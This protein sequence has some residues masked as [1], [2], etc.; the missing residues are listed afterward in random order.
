MKKVL[1]KKVWGGDSKGKCRQANSL[2]L[3]TTFKLSLTESKPGGF[4]SPEKGTTAAALSV[5]RSGDFWMFLATNIHA[6]VAQNFGWLFGPVWKHYFW[7]KNSYDWFWKF[8]TNFYSNIWSHWQKFNEQ[9]FYFLAIDLHRQE[10]LNRI[11]ALFF[12][13]AV[14]GS[15]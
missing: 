3:S 13:A 9:S 1:S 2:N 10:Y 5:T 11:L 12:R 14:F 6:K 15:V 8:W 7:S 4:F